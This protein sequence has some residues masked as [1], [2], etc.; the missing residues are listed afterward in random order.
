MNVIEAIEL[1]KY[2]KKIESDPNTPAGAAKSLR[3]H[4][5]SNSVATIGMLSPEGES[6]LYATSHAAVPKHWNGY[7]VIDTKLE[8]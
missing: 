6:V 2:I 5:G 4:L 7:R 8:V 1:I 3:E